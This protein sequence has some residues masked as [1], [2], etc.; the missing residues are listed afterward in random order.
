[1]QSSNL[2]SRQDPL[3]RFLSKNQNTDLRNFL[4]YLWVLHP[5]FKFAL[6]PKSSTP[7][8]SVS[9]VEVFELLLHWAKAAHEWCNFFFYQYWTHIF[10]ALL[11]LM[12]GR[13]KQY[14]TMITWGSVFHSLIKLAKCYDASFKFCKA[15]LQ[16]ISDIST[17]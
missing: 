7:L 3:I 5:N 6:V 11:R 10:I 17:C 14:S 4:F 2:F 15:V 13:C 16:V 9:V 12:K 1:M 8:V